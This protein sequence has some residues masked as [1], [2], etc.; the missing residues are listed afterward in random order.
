[1]ILPSDV[2]LPSG[3]SGRPLALRRT[4]GSAASASVASACR[5]RSARRAASCR[6]ARD[7]GSF[8]GG[9]MDALVGEEEEAVYVMSD[10]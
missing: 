4:A 10:N 1:M 9:G 8:K 2:S 3:S 7:G 6:L 5:R